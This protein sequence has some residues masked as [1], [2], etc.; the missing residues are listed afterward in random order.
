MQKF[1]N[2]IQDQFGNEITAATITVRN[3]VG[4]A[5]STL[6][7]DNGVTALGNPF[8]AQDASEFF[9]YAANARYDIFI[10]GPVTDSFLDVILFDQVDFATVDF[11]PFRT[12]QFLFDDSTTGLDPDAQ[13]IKFNSAT[14][15]NVTNTRIALSDVDGVLIAD[16]TN[17]SAI[18]S[19][20]RVWDEADPT[21]YQEYVLDEVPTLNVDHYRFNIDFIA[22]TTSMPADTTSLRVQFELSAFIGA[23]VVDGNQKSATHYDGASWVPNISVEFNENT[24][25]IGGRIRSP[26]SSATDVSRAM[27]FHAVGN[28]V[29]G[30]LYAETETNQGF[31]LYSDFNGSPRTWEFGYDTG[32]FQDIF[33]FED[34]P[35]G[36]VVLPATRWLW[37]EK[38]AADADIAGFGQFWVRNDAPNT[39]MFTDD[40][41]TDFVLNAGGAAPI[42]L[43]DNEQIQFGTGTDVTIDWDGVDLE[44]EGAAANQ[45]INFRDGFNLRMWDSGD[46][47]YIS[48]FHDGTDGWIG[49]L[50]S[51]WLRVEA[52]FD[53]LMIESGVLGL[54]EI[55]AAPADTASVGQF[56]VRNDVPNTPMFTDDTGIDFVLNTG[57]SGPL[58]ADLDADGFNLDDVGVLFMREQAAADVD[59]VGQGQFWVRDDAPN[60]PMFTDDVGTDF[61]LTAGASVSGAKAFGSGNQSIATGSS[62]KVV[63]LNSEAFDTDT[64]HDNVTNNSRLTVPTGITR[65]R[66]SGYVKW[67]P[68]GSS[69]RRLKVR[70]NGAVGTIDDDQAGF[71]PDIFTSAANASVPDLGVTI[72]T[73]IIRA[74]ATDYFELQVSQES[75]VSLNLLA[76]DYWFQMDLIE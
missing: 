30:T 17:L 42:V 2:N 19:R 28:S 37:G 11:G 61:V 4:G 21:Q 76:G 67:A 63:A 48:I 57:I 62:L 25:P 40:V 69:F 54:V 14:P 13:S 29:G 3:V 24:P 8:T 46:T 59:V 64:V 60:T 22:G 38:A 72:D 52:D 39:P 34:S 66:L 51:R 43:L 73:G 71:E 68:N 9:F 1:Q 65:V 75:G 41:G 55:A 27:I 20:M 32:A 12:G 15:A 31:Y 58:T 23:G 74:V 50:N 26:G 36:V 33:R 35:L 49:S 7:S 44:V 6:F 47:D 53:R 70:K 10:T 45:I 18:G 16:L 56:W 5:L